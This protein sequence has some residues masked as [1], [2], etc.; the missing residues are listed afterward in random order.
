MDMNI[1]INRYEETTNVFP[2]L[3]VHLYRRCT[4]PVH[5]SSCY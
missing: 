3:I 1:S 4:D 5:I 2:Y